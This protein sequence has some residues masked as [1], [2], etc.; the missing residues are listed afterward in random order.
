MLVMM[1]KTL[2]LNK[3]SKVISINEARYA[4]EQEL[5]FGEQ[6]VKIQI[7]VDNIEVLSNY[8]HTVLAS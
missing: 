3:S 1:E 5:P 6:S 8:S 4:R 2:T 7:N